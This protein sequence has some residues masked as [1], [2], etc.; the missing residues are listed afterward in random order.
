MASGSSGWPCSSRSTSGRRSSTISGI[1]T[2]CWRACCPRFRTIRTIRKGRRIS[3]QRPHLV[4]LQALADPRHHALRIAVAP[5][6][7]PAIELVGEV[8]RRLPGERRIAEPGAAPVGAVA[9][10]ARRDSR[11]ARRHAGKAWRCPGSA[12]AQLAMS[13]A[14]GEARRN[15]SRRGR[16]ARASGH[17]RWPP[18]ADARARRRRR[19]RAGARDS[20]GRARRGAGRGGRRLRPSGRDRWRTPR[21]RRARRRCRRSVRPSREGV[22]DRRRART[23][24]DGH[25]AAA[26]GRKWRSVIAFPEPPVVADGSR[27]NARRGPPVPMMR[28][29]RD[30]AR[31]VRAARRVQAAARA[32][33]YR[34]SRRGGARACGDRARRLRGLPPDQGRRLA[35]G[36]AGAVADRL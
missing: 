12:A 28:P 1:G 15:K 11:G 9:R 29:R 31:A 3:R 18:F 25:N 7:A 22:G 16:A 34:R 21:P 27:A 19:N 32:T 14:S 2:T 33:L 35:A 23:G 8:R 36:A 6:A 13:A 24:R 26:R 30:P 5:P 4:R 10:R 17:R 20:P